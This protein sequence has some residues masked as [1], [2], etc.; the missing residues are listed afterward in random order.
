MQGVLGRYQAG[1]LPQRHQEAALELQ[2]THERLY[3]RACNRFQ[4]GCIVDERKRL[5]GRAVAKAW[6]LLRLWNPGS[7]LLFSE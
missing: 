5:V 7:A 3:R 6:T 1:M 2:G 4:K